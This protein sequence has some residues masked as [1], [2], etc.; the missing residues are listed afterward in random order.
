MDPSSPT[1]GDMEEHVRLN[2][3]IPK[4]LRNDLHRAK[5]DTGVPIYKIVECLLRRHLDSFVEENQD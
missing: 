2:V 4:S 5:I 1:P 3:E